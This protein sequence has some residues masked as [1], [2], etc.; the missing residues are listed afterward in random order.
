MDAW[1]ILAKTGSLF[2]SGVRNAR[3]EPHKAH[4]TQRKSRSASNY[5][6]DTI[7]TETQLL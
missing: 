5:S 7:L 3:N 4:P 2:L 1:N 6:S